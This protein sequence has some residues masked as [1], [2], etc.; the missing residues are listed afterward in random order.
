MKKIVLIFLAAALV[1][2]VGCSSGDGS[3]PSAAASPASASPGADKAMP[4]E[5]EFEDVNGNIHKL[6]DYKGKPVYLEVWGTWCGVCMSALPD[7]DK[8]AGEDHDFVVLSV[9]TPG[10]AGEKN[11]DDFIK[12]FKGEDYKNLTVLLDENAQIVSDFGINA[13]PTALFFD[14]DGNV[15]KG[16]AGLVPEEA[17]T[18]IMKEIAAGTFT[19]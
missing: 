14:A 2:A 4:Y 10:V 3:A 19:G 11:K 16:Y 13:F 15:V 1:F 17:V 12:W 9:V 8:F 7:L 18:K 5:F 6:S